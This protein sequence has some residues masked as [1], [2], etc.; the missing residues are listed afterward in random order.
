MRSSGRI[1]ECHHCLGIIFLTKDP[2]ERNPA[3]SLGSSSAKKPVRK[4]KR[5]EDKGAKHREKIRE[6]AE[7]IEQAR[8]E[9]DLVHAQADLKKAKG[10]KISLEEEAKLK[11][12]QDMKRFS[13]SI[14]RDLR[15]Q[16]N[17]K[18]TLRDTNGKKHSG[19]ILRTI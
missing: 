2:D 18:T 8:L 16:S 9:K 11:H 12:E 7:L 15:E 10:E 1:R 13:T 19:R 17:S 14:V 6:Y 5:P 4:E 3:R